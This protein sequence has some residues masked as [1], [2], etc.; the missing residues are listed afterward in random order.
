MLK[1]KFYP[2]TELT[3]DRLVLKQLKMEDAP[4]I[5]LLR[6]DEQVNKYLDRPKANTLQDAQLFIKKINDGIANNEC[7]YWG[8]FSKGDPQLIGAIS[9]WNIDEIKQAVEIGYEL[10]PAQQGKGI[11]QEAIQPVIDFAF[12]TIRLRLIT[13]C[14]LESNELSAKLLKKNNF[15]LDKPTDEALT[16]MK[17]CLFFSLSNPD[18]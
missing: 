12:K 5:F 8:I 17:D 6:S 9:F 10:L 16:E 18:Q 1:P 14:T 7:M 3:T 15:Q 4:E 13:A 2:F 11:M